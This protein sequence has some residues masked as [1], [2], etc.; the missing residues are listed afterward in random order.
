MHEPDAARA[1]AELRPVREPGGR[2]RQSGE[3]AGAEQHLR[4]RPTSLAADEVEQPGA[5]PGA[6]DDVG[7]RWVD[8]VAEPRSAEDVLGGGV[9]RH[10]CAHAALEQAGNGIEERQPLEALG[11][12]LAPRRPE[13]AQAPVEEMGR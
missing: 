10:G 13:H 5:R 3:D 8:G 12:R 1:A 7:Q 4:A 6:D 2:C 11:D 9:L